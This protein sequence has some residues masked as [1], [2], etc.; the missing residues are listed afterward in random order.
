MPTAAVDVWLDGKPTPVEE[1]AKAELAPGKH[2]LVVG[3][4]RDQFTGDFH[5]KLKLR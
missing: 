2:S 1:I 4:N 5:V 3:I